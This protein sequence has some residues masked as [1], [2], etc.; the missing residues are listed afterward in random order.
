MCHITRFRGINTSSLWELLAEAE[1]VYSWDVFDMTAEVVYNWDVFVMTRSVQLWIS[2][3]GNEYKPSA[4]TI[5][6]SRISLVAWELII[7]NGV[8][9][10]K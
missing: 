10:S 2:R 8:K 7:Q 1:V 9:N 3:L 5:P 4:P 6:Q